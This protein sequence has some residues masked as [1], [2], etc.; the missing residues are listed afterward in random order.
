M[1]PIPEEV[2]KL[3]SAQAPAAAPSPKIGTSPRRST[4]AQSQQGPIFVSQAAIY[5][6][7]ASALEDT[8]RLY[9]LTKLHQE[10]VYDGTD[11]LNL[12][13]AYNGVV[14]P[15]TGETITKYKQLIQDPFAR[16]V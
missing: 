6:V 3:T 4:C 10:R 15:V 7:L 11:A 13:H 2:T 1:T 9:T 5:H 16:A 14:H 8:T 12:D